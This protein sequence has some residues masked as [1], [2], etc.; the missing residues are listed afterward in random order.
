MSA[1][2]LIEKMHY[3]TKIQRKLVYAFIASQNSKHMPNIT[4]SVSEYVSAEALIEKMHYKTE[5]RRQR[6]YASAEIQNP[7]HM[8]KN[9]IFWKPASFSRS[10]KR[11]YAL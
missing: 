7:K 6:V 4:F 2:A 11:K 9:M 8:P 1:E 3:K 5:I 10:P